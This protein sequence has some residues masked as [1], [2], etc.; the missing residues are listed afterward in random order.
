MKPWLGTT[1]GI[2]T[3]VRIFAI[4]MTGGVATG[5]VGILVLHFIG[6]VGGV[7]IGG[8]TIPLITVGAI[9]MTAGGGGKIRIMFKKS[10]FITMVNMFLPIQEKLKRLKLN[11]QRVSRRKFRLSIARMDPVW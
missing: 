10:M 3:T 5:T 9:G 1:I 7:I 11:L 8:G 4:T 6:L 2:I